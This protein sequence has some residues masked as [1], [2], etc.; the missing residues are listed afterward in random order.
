MNSNAN[1]FNLR[2]VKRTL[3]SVQRWDKSCRNVLEETLK[4]LAV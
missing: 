2:K 1:H 3:S 4:Y